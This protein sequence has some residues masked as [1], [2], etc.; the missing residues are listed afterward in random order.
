MLICVSADSQTKHGPAHAAADPSE[1]RHSRLLRI[2]KT[3]D[4]AKDEKHMV[5]KDGMRLSET[6]ELFSEFDNLEVVDKLVQAGKNVAKD[7]QQEMRDFVRYSLF[8]PS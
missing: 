8:C 4:E 7:Y 3:V 6:V 2:Q 1:K 5:D